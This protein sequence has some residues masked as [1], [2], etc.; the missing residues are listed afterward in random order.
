MASLRGPLKPDCPA[1]ELIPL[2]LDWPRTKL[3]VTLSPANATRAPIEMIG[4]RATTNRLEKTRLV[5]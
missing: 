1:A 2:K 3:A 5:I 4:T